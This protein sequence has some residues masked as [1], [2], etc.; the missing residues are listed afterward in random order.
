MSADAVRSTEAALVR[1]AQRKQRIFGGAWEEV[2]A[3]ADIVRHG[4][5]RPGRDRLECVWA[6][7]ESR[8][9]AQQADAAG[10]LAQIGFPRE[11]LAEDLNYSPMEIRRMD[12]GPVTNG[13]RPADAPETDREIRRSNDAAR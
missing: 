11:Q 10:K 8:T 7:P 2:V 12:F 9:I 13:A 6:D 5:R 4:Y 1:K 3:L